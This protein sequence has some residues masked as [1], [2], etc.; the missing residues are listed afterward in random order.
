MTAV[1]VRNVNIGEGR[2]KI[3][4]PLTGKDKKELCEEL[5]MIAT[6]SP[7]LVEWR[8]DF[9]EDAENISAVTGMATELRNHLGERPLIVTFRTK[10]EGGEK[11]VSED[12]YRELNLEVIRS[13]V[14]DLLDLELF[15]SEPTIEDVL[16][17]AKGHGVPVI[18]SNHEFSLTPPKE[19]ILE[20]LQ[21]M[22][23]HGADILKIAVMPRNAGDVLTLLDATY[24]F[25]SQSG[26]PPVVT[27]AMGG[28]GLITRL[29]GEIFGSALTFACGK[30]LSAPGQIPVNELRFVL[31]ILHK[32]K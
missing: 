21:K 20:R 11:L 32:N 23:E 30:K 1:T 9:F 17:E 16:K 3:V 2:P 25:N 7:D 4:V 18:M 10:K 28:L 24:T 31:D 22:K 15:S 29:S 14:A 12:Y 19:I 5:A 8:V 26:N 6:L 13:G 27:M